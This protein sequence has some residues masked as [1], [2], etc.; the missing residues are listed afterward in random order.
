VSPGSKSPS[1]HLPTEAEQPHQKPSVS[2]SSSSEHGEI[3]DSDE[4]AGLREAEQELLEEIIVK[5][6]PLVSSDP[7][8]DSKTI[9][10][11]GTI[12]EDEQEDSSLS[13]CK[14]LGTQHQL[15]NPITC[16]LF[17]DPNTS[18]SCNFETDPNEMPSKEEYEEEAEKQSPLTSG[19]VAT[20]SK[21]SLE[22]QAHSVLEDFSETM[23]GREESLE[24]LKQQQIASSDESENGQETK[25]IGAEISPESKEKSEVDFE[26][27][28]DS[29]IDE[30]RNVT[31]ESE[32][33]V[34]SVPERTD[35]P[36]SH[37][38]KDVLEIFEKIENENVHR[39][40]D[41][42][43]EIDVVFSKVIEKSVTSSPHDAKEV[44]SEI[45]ESNLV[46]ALADV[47][48]SEEIQIVTGKERF[49]NAFDQGEKVQTAE[50]KFG[51]V[52]SK[53]EKMVEA[54]DTI[55]ASS[56]YVTTGGFREDSLAPQTQEPC[57]VPE[58]TIFKPGTLK[59]TIVQASDLINQDFVGKSDPYVIVKFN[60]KVARSETIRETLEPFWNFIV[61]LDINDVKSEVII[62]VFD[63]DYG[64]DNYE[65]GL[66]L[67]VEELLKHAD[68]EPV[69]Y[70]L[71]GCKSG[72]ILIST[73]FSTSTLSVP[74][75]VESQV[76]DKKRTRYRSSASSSS[77][78]SGEVEQTSKLVAAASTDSSI[79]TKQESTVKKLIAQDTVEENES[80]ALDTQ[81][82]S[83]ETDEKNEILVM[84]AKTEKRDT[85][86]ES[87]DTENEKVDAVVS[88]S[89][90]DSSVHAQ[91]KR[92]RPES[93]VSDT[94]SDYDSL[95][96]VGKRRPQSFLLDDEYEIITE[97]EVDTES[98]ISKDIKHASL[99]SSDSEGPRKATKDEKLET[100]TSQTAAMS[101][102]KPS[103]MNLDPAE[104]GDEN[105]EVVTFDGISSHPEPF[106][107]SLTSTL[108]LHAE[109]FSVS[110]DVAQSTVNSS[111]T[112][113]G[114]DPLANDLERGTVSPTHVTSGLN[115][116]NTLDFEG[117]NA[118]VNALHPK[119][120]TLS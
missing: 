78:N 96:D 72:Q 79:S 98:K 83:R 40:A 14:D 84:D 27:I 39:N 42:E 97:E 87:S 58:S 114:I 15:V 12:A 45:Q 103:A 34:S 49:V 102:L 74:A 8:Q 24:D 13:E 16:S 73:S 86:S 37:Q 100:S 75:T 7:N 26:M 57:I 52:T 32:V 70:V 120:T 105:E 17:P 108:D 89:D 69:W 4:F 112:L 67:T 64:R 28:Q 53:I 38:M 5:D 107:S 36:S 60:D 88:S 91:P 19:F 92:Q 18:F 99:S 90:Y 6:D 21:D 95:S 109:Q 1:L 68:Y 106:P 76:A 54:Q 63:D 65:G 104:E 62:E 25:E 50:S 113:E 61:N 85:S 82:D 119:D 30:V 43:K 41:P 11:I 110:V 118:K 59:V 10:E 9:E 94:S 3:E 71:S 29:E 20:D 46:S 80:L 101:V 31:K 56:A 115:S 44:P 81:K 33:G 77:S 116:S 23:S 111:N 51:V 48:G 22:V 93:F 66:T 47:S 35:V 2:S 55:I 117:T